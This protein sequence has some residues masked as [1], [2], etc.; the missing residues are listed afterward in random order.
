MNRLNYNRVLTV[1]FLASVFLLALT[2][3]QHMDAWAHF[4]MGRRVWQNGLRMP[5]QD[6]PLYHYSSWFFGLIYYMAYHLFNFYGIVL[7][8]AT[9]VTTAFYILLKDSLKPHKN[10]VITI[11]ILSIVVIISRPRF[12]ERPDTFLMIFLPFS[13]YCLNAFVC[14]NKKYIYI[15][16]FMHMF[17]VNMHS[18]INLMFIPFFAFLIGGTLQ[19]NL[20]KRGIDFSNTPSK[21]H[22]KI[23]LLIL[24]LSFFASLI[25]PYGINQY[26]FGSKFLT[27]D[28][29]KQVVWEL[30]TP[31]WETNKWPFLITP[32]II[33]SFALNLLVAL[34]VKSNIP[35]PSIIY[36]LIILPFMILSFTAMRFT[37]LVA[38]VAAPIVIKNISLFLN[39]KR[40]N[41]F[42][43]SKSVIIG[44]ALWVVSYTTFILI[45]DAK[46]IGFGI[47]YDFVPEKALKYMDNKGITG[48]V[49]NLFNWGSYIIWRDF[50]K[51]SLFIE[52]SG[53]MLPASLLEKL[54]IARKHP[55][56]LDDFY[57]QYG[58]E[59]VI[60]DYPVIENNIKSD[61]DLSLSNP[62]WALVYWDDMSL[63]YLK[64]GGMYD[65]IIMEDGYKFIKPANGINYFWSKID[66]ENYRNEV[67]KE[68]ERN[69]KE[70]DSSKAYI[71]MGFLYNKTQH[72]GDAIRV[73][74]KVSS[75][76]A[77][78]DRALSYNGI[79]YAYLNLGNLDESIRY[80]KKSL[81][82]QEDEIVAYNLG[83]AYLKKGDK[84]SALKY[85][86]KALEIDRSLIYIYPALIGLYRELGRNDDVDRYGRIYEEARIVKEGEEHFK[87]GMEA[88][89]Q[90]KYDI[91]VEEL[92]KSIKIIPSSAAYSSLGYVYFDTDMLDKA[93]EYQQK[94]IDLNPDFANAHYG[95]AQIYKKKGDA[96][97][98]ERHFGE[99]LRIEPSGYF[100]RRA[101]EEIESIKSS[102]I[103]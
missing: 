58:F 18:S 19:I 94:A 89:L 51:R 64:N 76:T 102:G 46:S 79:G 63:V 54:N 75:D 92:H 8:K 55:D 86:E 61:V 15:L 67:V 27:S 44:L 88:Y 69:I 22:L 65:S 73:F 101:K 43:L 28:Y 66:D 36:S 52:P 90:Q 17:W 14:E 34:R 24:L 16:P 98:A 77:L 38:I 2:K 30:Q 39:I 23:I 99:Y 31:T 83:R 1:L 20:Q 49:F 103:K 7:L 4:S 87:S 78:A 12:V 9:S 84:K 68:L 93:L 3:I 47:D 41:A 91:A 13:I 29:Y 56:V 82:I 25:S 33:V 95:L 45:N 57:N 85:F 74:S 48:T 72:F 62:K 35:Y 70:T 10:F 26:T 97:M 21:S 71:Y 100:S 40:W 6:E 96:I 11:I 59:S 42:D 37:F 32:A 53:H 60:L 5:T 81:S 80:S 50:P